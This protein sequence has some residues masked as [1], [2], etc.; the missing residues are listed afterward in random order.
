MWISPSA[1]VS[2][3][4]SCSSVNTSSSQ[5]MTLD[6]G[7]ITNIK[8]AIDVGVTNFMFCLHFYFGI[9][10]TIIKTILTYYITMAIVT[11]QQ[12]PHHPKRKPSANAEGLIIHDSYSSVNGAGLVLF[13]M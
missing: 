5:K 6:C 12:P 4:D 11:A 13:A 1:F 3:T 2:A 10:I 9:R 7:Y 8:A